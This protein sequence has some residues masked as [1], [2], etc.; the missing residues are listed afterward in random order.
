L[1][2]HAKIHNFAYEPVEELD[3]DGEVEDPL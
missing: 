2:G 3:D 1:T